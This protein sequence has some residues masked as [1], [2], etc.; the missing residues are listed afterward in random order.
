MLHRSS[1]PSVKELCRSAI[2]D[3]REVVASMTNHPLDL[4]NVLADWRAEAEERCEQ[5]NLIIRWQQPDEL[6]ALMLSPRQRTNLSRILRESITNVIK[7][8]AA[9][10]LEVSIELNNLQLSISC[11]DNGTGFDDSCFGKGRG[12]SNMRN[13]I[14]DIDGEIIWETSNQGGCCV[15]WRVPLAS[16][17]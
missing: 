3:L 7:H 4:S 12:T 15:K 11:C 10:L 6:P 13:R 14:I 8:S 16:L 5:A 17:L 2:Q 9:N 1:E